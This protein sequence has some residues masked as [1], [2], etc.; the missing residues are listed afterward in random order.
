MAVMRAPPL[1]AR[2]GSSERASEVV[3]VGCHVK[4]WNVELGEQ[5]PF[6]S[7]LTSDTGGGSRS[8]N[9]PFALGA[10]E[11]QVGR[12]R[13]TERRGTHPLR[14][15]AAATLT[16]TL[17][18]SSGEIATGRCA[19][20][21]GCVRHLRTERGRAIGST[22][23]N[24]SPPTPPTS[25]SGARC[26]PARVQGADHQ[27]RRRHG[28]G[29]VD[30]LEVSM[31]SVSSSAGSRRHAHRSISRASASSKLR[32][33]ARPVSRRARQS[34]QGIDQGLQPAIA[35]GLARQRGSG[36]CCSS[37]SAVSAFSTRA[38]SAPAGRWLCA[39]A[40]FTCLCSVVPAVESRRGQ[41]SSG[42]WR[43][44]PPN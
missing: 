23:E 11:L 33:L 30:P 14:A 37:C 26:R 5:Q 20:A 32:R 41:S 25:P 12:D 39:R 1:V 19:R 43:D 18:D 40:D 27:G 24:S 16:V 35:H 15:N 3:T 34:T 7:A 29:V 8:N 17:I 44:R 28:H 13:A 42:P 10:V 2:D 38:G 9:S 4:S 21:G 31:S 6:S 36:R 22:M